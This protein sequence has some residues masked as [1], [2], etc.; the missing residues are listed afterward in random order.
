[1]QIKRPKHT[2]KT[3]ASSKACCLALGQL[4]IERIK[5]AQ[6]KKARSPRRES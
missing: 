1:M 4:A 6:F 2:K 5:K 3:I